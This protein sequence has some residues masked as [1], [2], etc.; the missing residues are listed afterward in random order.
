MGRC[1]DLSAVAALHF[2]AS[3][4]VRCLQ[5]HDSWPVRSVSTQQSPA[6]HAAKLRTEAVPDATT[7]CLHITIFSWC[8][9]L[10]SQG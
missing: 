2:M 3:K 7:V 9:C 6:R 5:S 1:V 4:V 8:P 10:D